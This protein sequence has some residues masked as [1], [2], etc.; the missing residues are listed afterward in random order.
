MLKFLRKPSWPFLKLNNKTLEDQTYKT[1]T[2]L[3]GKTTSQIIMD[4]IAEEVKQIKATGVREPHLAAILVGEDPASNTY[5]RN[6][7]IAC[8][9]VG[10]KST[11]IHLEDTVSQEELLSKIDEL[12]EDPD[13]DGFIVQLPL[14]DHIDPAKVTAR[15]NPAKDVDGFTVENY[16]RIASKLPAYMPA[17][18]FGVIELLK[19]YDIDTTGKHCVVVGYSRIVGAPMAMLMT[20]PWKATVTT[21]HIHTK[22]LSHH[23][24]QAD[25]LIV[26]VGK[27]GL[28][29]G[30]MIKP[31]AVVIDI[32]TTR[33]KDESKKSGFSLKGDVLYQEAMNKA[34]YLTPVPGGVGPMTIAALL[35]NTLYATQKKIYK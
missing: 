21:C 33:I 12:N 31:G 26:A 17:T 35:L 25:I 19:R 34:S 24:L 11:F 2:L 28:I 4:E 3:D 30:D 5:V 10:Y 9:K 23:T 18:A 8:D 1:A 6:K 29:T 20:G 32:G 15:I 22:D 13:L 27:P 14:P 16:G 7:V